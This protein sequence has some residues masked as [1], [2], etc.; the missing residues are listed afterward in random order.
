MVVITPQLGMFRWNQDTRKLMKPQNS[1]IT[2]KGTVRLV[3]A[4]IAARALCV[5]IYI[6]LDTIVNEIF[7]IFLILFIVGMCHNLSSGY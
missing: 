4:M 7:F 5:Y 6:F 1:L 3:S 2:L